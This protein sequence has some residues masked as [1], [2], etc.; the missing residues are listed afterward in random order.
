MKHVAQFERFKIELTLEQA[1]RGS[2][3]GRCEDDIAAL[4][5]EPS[6]R[7]QL[8]RIDPAH[9]IDE[10]DG[11]DELTEEQLADHEE[12]LHRILWIACGDILDNLPKG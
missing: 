10:L 2:H 1:K 5:Q 7:E 11:V 3:A 12:N 9:A 6:I 8:N 4:R